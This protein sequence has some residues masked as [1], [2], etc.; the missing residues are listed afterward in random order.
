MTTMGT[1]QNI[2]DIISDTDGNRLLIIDYKSM[3]MNNKKT[4]NSLERIRQ[5]FA[6]TSLDCSKD[7]MIAFLYGIV[8]GWDD[9]SFKEL[10]DLHNWSDK[11]VVDIK[12]WHENYIK[13]MKLLGGDNHNN[14]VKSLTVHEKAVI[15]ICKLNYEKY[16]DV[17]EC[18]KAIISSHCMCFY[19]DIEPIQIL[20]FMRRLY[21]KVDNITDTLKLIE[22]LECE[23]TRSV[24]YRLDTHYFKTQI[25]Q[26]T[27]RLRFL[28]IT[29]DKNEPIIDIKLS[30][31]ER[32]F[33]SNCLKQIQHTRNG[34]K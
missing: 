22:N 30:K 31:D 16:G 15:M 14:E 29:N 6:F 20:Q 33:V 2:G 3:I 11:D 23:A 17:D 1:H 34:R 24:I 7:K 10:M 26:Y 18:L 32:T 4:E 25:L 9:N 13:T 27:H 21:I 8:M 19:E 5:T 28:N 12:M